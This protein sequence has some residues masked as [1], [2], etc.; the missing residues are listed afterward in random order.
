MAAK[1][2]HIEQFDLS[3]DWTFYTERLGQFFVAND[4]TDDP[5]KVAVLLT[6]IGSKPYELL[7]NLLA[8]EA[9]ALKKYEELVAASGII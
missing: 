9:P 5:K 3:D 8:P 4:I 7:H 2:G 1:L 6:V